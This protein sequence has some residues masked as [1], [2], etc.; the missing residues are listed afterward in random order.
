MVSIH[1]TP[2]Y[3]YIFLVA[4]SH[5][6][7][8]CILCH[9]MLPPH[10]RAPPRCTLLPQQT[11]KVCTSTRRS[12]MRAALVSIPFTNMLSV[13]ERF[14]HKDATSVL[15]QARHCPGRCHQPLCC[16]S[17]PR[18]THVCVVLERHTCYVKNFCYVSLQFT[19]FFSQKN[20]T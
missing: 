18:R 4:M 9:V 1:V 20:I 14:Q 8:F 3:W 6:M 15:G 12:S 10:L 17:Q 7:F 2:F 16:Q 11:P 19:D 5:K 13:S